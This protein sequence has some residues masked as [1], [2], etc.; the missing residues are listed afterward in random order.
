M[1]SSKDLA[2]KLNNIL[3]TNTLEQVKHQKERIA[4]LEEVLE[5]I[6]SISDRDHMYWNRAKE[7]LDKSNN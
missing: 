3:L 2:L 7:L 4:E 1:T 6:I 5:Q